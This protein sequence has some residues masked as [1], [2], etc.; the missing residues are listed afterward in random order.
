MLVESATPS[1]R[2][3]ASTAFVGPAGAHGRERTRTALIGC[4][5]RR[6][7]V[8]LQGGRPSGAIAWEALRST[9]SQ[10][11]RRWSACRAA[12]RKGGDEV[13]EHNRSEGNKDQ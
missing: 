7:P 5:P 3:G 9:R 2:Y 13:G 12:G 4:V 6:A 10:D 11:Q 8:N 1:G